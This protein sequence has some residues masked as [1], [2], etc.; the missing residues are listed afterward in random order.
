M[1]KKVLIPLPLLLRIIE[2]LEYWDISEYNRAIREEYDD[3]QQSLAVKMQK[4]E[5]RDAYAKII[6]A[7][8]EDSRHDARIDYL[9]KKSRLRADG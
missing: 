2:L 6:A 7:D 5:L 9:W 3:V 1:E 8:N 4:L